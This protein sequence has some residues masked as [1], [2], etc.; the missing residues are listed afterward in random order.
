MLLLFQVIAA[1]LHYGGQS[2]D[3]TGEG[4]YLRSEAIREEQLLILINQEYFVLICRPIGGYFPVKMEVSWR[5]LSI[6]SSSQH[7]EVLPLLFGGCEDQSAITI[8]SKIGSVPLC[9]GSL[10]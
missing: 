4:E 1:R 5:V 3:C 2:Q 6:P 10:F 8:D 7:Q 9:G